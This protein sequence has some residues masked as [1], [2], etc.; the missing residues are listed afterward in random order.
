MRQENH[1][2]VGEKKNRKTNSTVWRICYANFIIRFLPTVLKGAEVE[3]KRKEECRGG[4]E[5]EEEERLISKP[6][7]PENSHLKNLREIKLL[8]GSLIK[9]EQKLGKRKF[10]ERRKQ[11]RLT[12]KGAEKRGKEEKGRKNL[13]E[14]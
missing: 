11:K 7:L 2:L 1:F 5:G 9:L 4:R 8:N 12:I 3:R 10:K 6:A 13:G 14:K